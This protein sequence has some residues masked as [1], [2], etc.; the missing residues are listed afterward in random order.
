VLVAPTST[1]SV[2][3]IFRPTISIGDE[4][5]QM[6]VDQTSSVASGARAGL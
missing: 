4:P 5:T 2:A 3:T 1:S 6:L